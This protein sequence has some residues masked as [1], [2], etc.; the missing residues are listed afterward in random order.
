[1]NASDIA[2]W[3]ELETDLIKVARNSEIDSNT[4]MISTFEGSQFETELNLRKGST[5]HILCGEGR[6]IAASQNKWQSVKWQN[7]IRDAKQKEVSDDSK[8]KS[9]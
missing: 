6:I 9:T 3:T 5:Y 8:T 7:M 4:T 1:M 2:D